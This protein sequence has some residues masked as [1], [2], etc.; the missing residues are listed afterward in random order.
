M[1]GRRTIALACTDRGQHREW[2]VYSWLV[3]ETATPERMVQTLAGA[4]LEL[5]CPKC[6]RTP[7]ISHE[8]LLRLC[9]WLLAQ[10]G[11]VVLDVSKLPL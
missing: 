6:P 1:S 4:W 8:R 11:R 10:P 5:D 3:D 2:I 7:R 9:E